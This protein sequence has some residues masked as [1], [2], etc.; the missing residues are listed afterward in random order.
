MLGTQIGAKASW[1]S[2]GVGT[3]TALALSVLAPPPETFTCGRDLAAWI[4]LTPRIATAAA[5][6]WRG[7]PA[8]ADFE[9]GPA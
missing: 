9:D 7:Q 3:V 2:M 4:G 1:P 6:E 8:G 5:F